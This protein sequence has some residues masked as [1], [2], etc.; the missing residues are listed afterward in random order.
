MPLNAVETAFVVGEGSNRRCFRR[1]NDG[2]SCRCGG[3]LVTVA[4]PHG[5]G[6]GLSAH[7]SVVCLNGNIGGT[8]FAATSLGNSST[9]GLSHHLE[10]VANTKDRNAEF[11]DGR[12]QGGGAWLID[13]GRTTGEHNAYG[14]LGRDLSSSDRVRNNLGIHACFANAARNQLCILGAEVNDEDGLG[15]RHAASPFA[16]VGVVGAEVSWV[17]RN[18]TTFLA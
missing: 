8:V 14:V 12:V 6:G 9:E 11:E 15:L 5:L 18:A 16:G 4:H 17:A 7:E 1:G 10:A 13:A 2:E 3:N